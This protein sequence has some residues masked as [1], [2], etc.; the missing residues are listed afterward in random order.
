MP[1]R[2]WVKRKGS[3]LQLDL[4]V[5]RA[6]RGEPVTGLVRLETTTDS[7]GQ[8]QSSDSWNSAEID[9]LPAPARGVVN[10]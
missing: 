7:E 2:H 3:L 5:D 1:R 6:Y 4:P 8:H 10:P 9:G